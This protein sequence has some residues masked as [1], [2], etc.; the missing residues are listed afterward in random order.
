MSATTR[1][2]RSAHV[3]RPPRP[4]EPR[5]GRS[6]IERPLPPSPGAEADGAQRWSALDHETRRPVAAQRRERLTRHLLAAADLVAANL[7]LVLCIPLLGRGDSLAI[8]TVVGISL[9]VLVLG[10]VLGLYDRDELMLRPSTL[11]EA[12]HLFQLATLFALLVWLAGHP[13][14]GAEL[15]RKQILGLWC[16][17]FLALLAC[18]VVA[19]AFARR[20]APADNCLLAGEARACERA[21]RKIGAARRVNAVVVA[22]VTG[23]DV[24]SQGLA[25]ATMTA[26]AGRTDIHRVIVAPGDSDQSELLDLIRAAKALGLKVSVLPRMFEVVGSAVTF[27]DVEGVTVLGVRRFGLTRSSALVKRGL[28]LA[29]A[30]LGLVVLSP[31]I[32]LIAAAIRLESRGPVFFRQQRVGRDGRVF[33]ML[34]FRTMVDGADGL[35][36][37]LREYNEADG[38]FKIA[39]DPRI[40]RV[41]RVLRRSSLDELPQ[42]WN[43][44]GGEMSLV[45][46]RPLVAEDDRRV[47]GWDRR[48]LYLTP[49]MTGRWQVLGSARIPLDEMVSIDYLYAANWSLWSDVKILLRTVPYMV[50]RRG[51]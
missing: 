11:D 39:A 44:L 2:G 23:E 22:Q 13:V 41:G 19:R 33:T 5:S 27:D 21:R 45:G 26:L 36:D 30:T 35:K 37:R 48:R 6:R 43:V 9:L 49:G 3:I 31:L 25:A 16:A 4:I 40:T 32:A 38:L 20:L 29:G 46:P 1:H 14:V 42:L 12:P 8:A 28:D 24:G 47:E 15:G 10:K 7:A 18:R 34:K 50:A 17:L 51:M